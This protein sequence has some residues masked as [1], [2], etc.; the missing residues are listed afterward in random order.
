MVI[1]NVDR[2]TVSVDIE[3]MRFNVERAM[4]LVEAS[5]LKRAA[6][7]N[8]CGVKVETLTKYLNGHTDPSRPVVMHLAR[9]LEVVEAELWIEGSHVK[10]AV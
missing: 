3:F 5:P 7:A 6:I 10:E 9:V 2:V 1:F 4:S 8:A